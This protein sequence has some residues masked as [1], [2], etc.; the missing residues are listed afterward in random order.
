MV[1]FFGALLLTIVPIRAH[2][3]VNEKGES[4]TRIR[5]LLGD[6][7]DVVWRQIESGV[8]ASRLILEANE[9]KGAEGNTSEARDEDGDAELSP[10]MLA[11]MKAKAL[12]K[13]RLGVEC[14]GCIADGKGNLL[15]AD[16]VH[17]MQMQ[18]KNQLEQSQ[19]KKHEVNV[20]P[21]RHELTSPLSKAHRFLSESDDSSSREIEPKK[22]LGESKQISFDVSSS[23]I[24]SSPV[25]EGCR[26]EYP[27]EDFYLPSPPI[28]GAGKGSGKE[29]AQAVE[30]TGILIAAEV[31]V[32]VVVVLTTG[33]MTTES[34]FYPLAI[35]A[36]GIS[37]TFV[38]TT[39]NPMTPK[40]GLVLTFLV[41]QLEE[42][43]KES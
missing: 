24:D 19:D 6:A 36:A 41:S 21:S 30:G 42:N 1:A 26:C 18:T 34:S 25:P 7:M 31:L 35:R 40:S 39:M 29:A 23:T 38:P 28:G 14:I 2:G 8:K 4:L 33:L 5:S 10:L 37:F 11:E 3:T 13:Q 12:E 32:E 9:G 16:L 27:G 15:P 22:I 43:A 20:M 17:A